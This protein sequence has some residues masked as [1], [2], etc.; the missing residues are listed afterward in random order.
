MERAWV[1]GSLICET[2]FTANL[3]TCELH[4]PMMLSQ[5]QLPS[6]SFSVASTKLLVIRQQLRDTM[7]AV[8]DRTHSTLVYTTVS[9]TVTRG[10]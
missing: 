6:A 10:T 8:P 5:T 7:F 1:F 4:Q 3:D 2:G 9:R